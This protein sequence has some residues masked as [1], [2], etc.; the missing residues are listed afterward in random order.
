M[1]SMI[2]REKITIYREIIRSLVKLDPEC[3][4]LLIKNILN[5]VVFLPLETYSCQST[6]KQR[7]V[8]CT[9]LKKSPENWRRYHQRTR[10]SLKYAQKL[11]FG[12]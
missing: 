3:K 7:T 10:D 11:A 5:K 2:Y 9:A 6:I 1:L 12:K 8:F 4:E